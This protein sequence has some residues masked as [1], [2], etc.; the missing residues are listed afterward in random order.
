MS[1]LYRRNRESQKYLLRKYCMIS[2]A[3]AGAIMLFVY[4]CHSN[5]LVFGDN[6]VLRMDL[7]HQ[8]GPLYAELYDRIT[9]GYSLVYSWTS[10][11]GGSFLGNLFNYCCS[12][13]ALVMLLFGHKGM[14]EA[15][16]VIILLKAVCS[17]MTFSYY[18]NKTNK[19]VSRQSIAFGLL[20]AFCGYFVAFSWN[21]MWL[22]AMAVF[23]LVI[24]GI[25]RIIKS[26]K[27]S[28][29][30]FA[31]TYTMITNY[32]MAYMVC[33]LSVIYFLYFYLGNYELA[34]KLRKPQLAD[35]L[36]PAPETPET[37]TEAA[38]S[39]EPEA[40]SVETETVSAEQETVS[41]EPE[42]AAA[43]P[44]NSVSAEEN[45]AALFRESDTVISFKKESVFKRLGNSRFF[46][47]GCSFA[48]SSFL[49][50]MLS[51]FA[52]LPVYYCLQSSSATQGSF[53]TDIKI[54]F[55]IFDFIANH[56][57]AL[58]TT[59]RS[60]GDNVLPNVYC[61]I[62]C[63]LSVPLFFMS[64]RISGRKKVAAA[65]LLG[66]FYMSFSVNYFN[67]VWHGFH[68]PNDLPYRYSF[69]YSFI[70][71]TLAYKVLS[72]I[73][74]YSRRML[75][76]VGISAMLYVVLVQKIGSAN[77]ERSAVVISILFIAFY[78]V[79][80]G[81]FSSPSYSRNAVVSLLIFA[82]VLEICFADT[83]K[84]VMAQPKSA[85]T[86]DYNDY[87]LV[88]EDTES[89]DSELFYRTE[90]TKLRARMDPCWYGYNGVSTFSSMAYEP[91]AKLM[92]KLGMFGNNINSYTYYP[93]TP[94]FNS[95]FALKYIYDKNS[96]ISDNDMYTAINSG[97][98]FTGYKYNYYLPLAF[99]TDDGII[100]ADLSAANPFVNQNSY[101]GAAT[102]IGD[103][104]IQVPASDFTS[105]NLN[106]VPVTTV[107]SGTSFAVNKTTNG[108]TAS[109]TV[110]I[111]VETDGQYYVYMGS[112]RLSSVKITAENYEYSYASSS[113]QPFTLD[114]GYQTAGSQIKIVY[115]LPDDYDS[116][117][118][119]FCAAR[120]DAEQFK[121]A[122]EK[123][124]GGGVINL[125]SFEETSFTGTIDV[126][127]DGSIL[128]TSIPFDASWNVLVDG[129]PISYAEDNSGGIVKVANAL[130]GV[131]LSKGEHTV[132]FN[133]AARGLS[134]GIKLTALGLALIAFM[135]IYK[136]WLRAMLEAR[137][138]NIRL[139]K[140]FDEE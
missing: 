15:I 72:N 77:A 111:D 3:L 86:S 133:Y 22:D 26:N 104:L 115:N 117:S 114:V 91:V 71:L 93:Q 130:M 95:M 61:G 44:E 4:F 118:L 17:A 120:L 23:P 101:I 92:E 2:G 33:I 123:L 100:D 54:Y 59:I 134:S 45:V 96:L 34:S 105:D 18:I 98:T 99:C 13:F 48:L 87:Q 31:M 41:A 12:P 80:L 42:T 67:F 43:E 74:E 138:I 140:P 81:L 128:Y 36:Q 68:M 40:D 112:T 19:E 84:F 121:K 73:D 9:N 78:I 50:F 30:I 38:D 108:K 5:T 20:Y 25:E 27:P 70:L 97:E 119:T 88:S 127:N 57:P 55:N 14:P 53:P 51:A 32:Y 1:I 35:F 85:Y 106:F 8:Y 122:F 39:A 82:V 64:N 58:N 109:G 124:S 7:Y 49:C 75:V 113:I 102:G 56:L 11:L 24:L 139:F 76:G 90:L 16:A 63:V 94:I 66:V 69:A 129:Q 125:S 89:G 10:G 52:L 21:I 65:V 6:T 47:S 62:L 60:S 131:R 46:I 107:N 79:V 137:K 110:V 103:V 29:Y 135:L 126:K 132:S 83:S 37:V 136:Y 116:A 28:L